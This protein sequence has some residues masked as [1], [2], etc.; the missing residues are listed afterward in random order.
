[1]EE[2]RPELLENRRTSENPLRESRPTPGRYKVVQGHRMYTWNQT[3]RYQHS[4]PGSALCLTFP[5][6][7]VLICNGLGWAG[8]RKKLR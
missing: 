1:M 3:L 2:A 4:S 7:S 6:L 8:L 5:G